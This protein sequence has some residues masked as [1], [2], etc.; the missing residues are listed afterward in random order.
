MDVERNNP[1]GQEFLVATNLTSN[2]RTPEQEAESLRMQAEEDKRWDFRPDRKLNTKVVFFVLAVFVFV[3]VLLLPLFDDTDKGKSE[4]RCLAVLL[5]ACILWASEAL[6][7]W[8]TSLSIILLSE[9]LN[10]QFD[11]KSADSGKS[12]LAMIADPNVILLMGGFTIAA[13]L[14]KYGIDVKVASGVQSIV[15]P[16][17][18]RLF[19]LVNMCVGFLISMFCNN[20]AAPVVTFFVVTPI[21]HKIQDRKY[22]CCMIMSIAFACNIGGMPTPIASPQNAQASQV[23]TD[24]LGEKPVSMVAWI[25]FSM[26]IC[27]V[28]IPVT[29]LLNL[30]YWKPTLQTIPIE[31]PP[32]EPNDTTMRSNITNLSTALQRGPWGWKHYYTLVI[33]LATVLL[34][35]LFSIDFIE[36]I[37]GQM[38]MVGLIPVIFLYGAGV[39]QAE[40]FKR[41]DWGILMLLGGGSALGSAVKTSGLLD[42]IADRLQNQFD[43]WNLN[44]YTQFM[45][46]N[47]AVIFIAN[48]ISHTVAAITMLGVV[49]KVGKSINMGTAFVLGGVTVDSGACALPVSSFPNVI[50]YG[51]KDADGVGYL[52]ASDYL[53]IS[54]AVEFCVLI[55]MASL[56]WV[57]AK[58]VTG[59]NF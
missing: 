56:G 3:V 13:A 15:G 5:F 58:Q 28:L 49:G 50:A 57:M 22:C 31:G 30:L 41:M 29:W 7:L 43:H 23:I 52:K 21:L 18:P 17:Y 42:D 34:W 14:H 25:C 19:I 24:V 26:P 2:T 51:I 10:I 37:F 6:P 9:I 27:A 53:L 12:L 32:E 16:N 40:D 55:T 38:G 46:F 48:F 33:T 11:A 1:G 35:C 20:V 59:W 36:D 45:F 4:K 54:F 8:V 47:V 39:L 44:A